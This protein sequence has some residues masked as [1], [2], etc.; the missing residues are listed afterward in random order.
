MSDVATYLNRA[1]SRLKRGD[2]TGAGSNLRRAA[3]A[4]DGTPNPPEPVPAPMLVLC[5]SAR[6][7]WIPNYQ[8]FAADEVLLGGPAFDGFHGYEPGIPASWED[9]RASTVTGHKW[10][11]ANVKGFGSAAVAALVEFWA[12]CPP[13]T[14]TV[15]NHEADNPSKNIDPAN[16]QSTYRAAY[17]L[18][19][20]MRDQGT[21][22]R[23]VTLWANPMSYLWRAND[24]RD[25]EDWVP[26]TSAGALACDGVLLN[27]YWTTGDP[28][29]ADIFGPGLAWLRDVFG[30]AVPWG[31]GEFSVHTDSHLGQLNGAGVRYSGPA[32]DDAEAY[33]WVIATLNAA[34]S[35]GCV[36]AAYFSSPVGE[37]GPWNLDDTTGDAIGDW[38]RAR[39]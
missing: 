7:P 15:L 29:F 10:A 22:D 18:L 11:M 17:D 34:A 2:L 21:V 33:D 8:A 19:V 25:P 37:R 30:A 32:L 1:G 35:D 28:T 6:T 27:G 16:F 5:A 9:H 14:I 23:T 13:N 20:A 12:S 38:L 31:I 39:P 3:R 36:A 4:L 26:I 24:G